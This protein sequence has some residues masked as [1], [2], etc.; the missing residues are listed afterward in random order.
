MLTEGTRASKHRMISQGS[1]KDQVETE[2]AVDVTWQAFWYFVGIQSGVA[3]RSS[4]LYMLGIAGCPAPTPFSET[5]YLG[6]ELLAYTVRL[7]L[8]LFFTVGHA[9]QV[10]HLAISLIL[11]LFYI[12]ILFVCYFFSFSPSTIGTSCYFIL[13]VCEIRLS[14]S[15]V[16]LMILL[17]LPFKYHSTQISSCFLFTSFFRDN[18]S[19]FPGCLWIQGGLWVLNLS[20]STS[21][22][23][24][25]IGV[26][27]GYFIW[28]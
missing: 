13:L 26:H 25:I 15:S 14:V 24:G 16:G 17:P 23:A 28:C 3:W 12:V 27:H 7:C 18:A 11:L 6:I 9:R 1:L 2:A 22:S 5:L 8:T 10:L 4:S 20:T 19:S 21:L